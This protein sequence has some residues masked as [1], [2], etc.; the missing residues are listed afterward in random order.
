MGETD[1]DWPPELDALLAAPANHRLLHEDDSVRLVEVSIEPGERENLHCH[2]WPSIMIIL[3]RPQFLFFDGNG[4]P[5]PPVQGTTEP[6][7]LP[8]VVRMPPQGPH[9]VEVAADAPHR[10]HAFRIELKQES[11]RSVSQT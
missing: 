11:N 2:G 5:V 6:P 1:S 7:A 4:N 9:A 10:F 8:R 3:A